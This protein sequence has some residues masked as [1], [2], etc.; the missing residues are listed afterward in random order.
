MNKRDLSELSVSAIGFGCM[1]LSGIYGKADDETSVLLLKYAVD[2]GVDFFDTADMYGGGHNE[3]LVG[4]ALKAVRDKVKIATKFGN[5]YGELGFGPGEVCGRPDYV[6]KACDLSLKRLNTDYIDLYYQHRVDPQ[7]PIEETVGAMAELKEK[8]KILHLG[9]S[10]AS[11]KTI[12][13]AQK[14]HKITAVQCEYSLWWRKLVEEELT[15][16]LK[17]H[18]IG[19]VAYSPLGRGLLTGAIKGD[20]VFE[21]GDRRNDHPR[22]K[23][24]NLEKNL[25]LVKELSKISSELNVTNAQLSLAWVLSK[26]RYIVPIPGTKSVDRLKENLKAAEIKLSD[27]IVAKLEDIFKYENSCGD[28]YP[29]Q[30]MKRVNL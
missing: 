12:E 29:P 8:G 4:K 26:G 24:E 2:S 1:S 16:V 7:V 30:Q 17:Q 23:D 14:T 9:L 6:K 22:F 20:T 5:T 25:N 11:G 3:T 19:L 18:D 28:R 13:L 15:A 10:E 21:Q 27:E